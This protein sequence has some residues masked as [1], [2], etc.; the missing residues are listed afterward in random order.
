M[1]PYGTARRPE[2]SLWALGGLWWTL[3]GPAKSH[4]EA[5][6]GPFGSRAV[7]RGPGGRS[8]RANGALCLDSA[9][10]SVKARCTSDGVI[11]STPL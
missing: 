7:P 6:L 5:R 9:V 3:R 11:V 10:S 4:R 1:G 8:R 2:G